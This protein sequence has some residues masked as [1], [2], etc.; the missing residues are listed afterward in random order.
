M[1]HHYESD[2]LLQYFV[3]IQT[4]SFIVIFENDTEKDERFLVEINYFNFSYYYKYDN[5][6]R[7]HKKGRLDRESISH[8]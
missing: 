7:I 4:Y 8:W 3:N 1:L 5:S 2:S 6:S